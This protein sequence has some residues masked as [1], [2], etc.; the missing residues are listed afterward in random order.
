MSKEEPVQRDFALAPLCS[1]LSCK[2][3]SERSS[4]TLTF[5]YNLDKY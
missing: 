2:H 3:S 1:L 4:Q 5:V